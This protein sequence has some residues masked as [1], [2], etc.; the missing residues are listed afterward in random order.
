MKTVHAVNPDDFIAYREGSGGTVEI[1]DIVVNSA[2]R[3]GIG[4]RL[5]ENLFRLVG[6]G[7]RV[8]AIT[9]I[10]NEIAVQFYQA[11]GFEIIGVLRR[12][13]SDSAGGVDALMF[14]RSSEGPI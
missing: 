9:R 5:L 6:K 7:K 10:E 3:K 14:G 12:F 2:R 4:R 13:Y 11:C 8:F 1:Y